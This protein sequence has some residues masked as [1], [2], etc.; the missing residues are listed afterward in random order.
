MACKGG[1]LFSL[2]KFGCSS[3]KE[4]GGGQIKKLPLLGLVGGAFCVKFRIG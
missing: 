3:L 4:D 2:E 1:I